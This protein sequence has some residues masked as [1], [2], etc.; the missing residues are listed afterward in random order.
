MNIILYQHV[1]NPDLLGKAIVY[2]E[3]IGLTRGSLLDIL[4]GDLN[5]YCVFCDDAHV[6]MAPY[7]ETPGFYFPIIGRCNII[8]STDSYYRDDL[9]NPQ[10]NIYSAHLHSLRGNNMGFI[11]YEDIPKYKRINH[12]WWHT[13]ES[14]SHKAVKVFNKYEPLNWFPALGNP[15]ISTGYRIVENA[16][17]HMLSIPAAF[18]ESK[19]MIDYTSYPDIFVSPFNVINNYIIDGCKLA[20]MHYL[21]GKLVY[22]LYNDTYDKHTYRICVD[23]NLNELLQYKNKKE[24]K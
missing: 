20:G 15:N 19:P 3:K 24:N 9:P 23:F 22:N 10:E 12:G 2:C 14:T 6:S 5:N 11:H 7:L 16:P 4:Q 21:I 13:R 1:N 18:L 17:L 8:P